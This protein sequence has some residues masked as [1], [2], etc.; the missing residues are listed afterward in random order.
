MPKVIPRI[1]HSLSAS[2]VKDVCQWR[3]C[4]P[5]FAHIWVHHLFKAATQSQANKL[6][7]KKG[8]GQSGLDETEPV[9][10]FKDEWTFNVMTFWCNQTDPL[11]YSGR[12]NAESNRWKIL[13]LSWHSDVSYNYD[14]PTDAPYIC[15]LT[16]SLSALHH[17]LCMQ[18]LHKASIAGHSL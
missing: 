14:A 11:L 5:S 2:C 16:I 15:L 12:F 8:S 17:S 13:E 18:P 1:L 7:K 10:N 3:T 4:R 6:G 9:K